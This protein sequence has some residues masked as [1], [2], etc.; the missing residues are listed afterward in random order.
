MQLFQ[1]TDTHYLTMRR[2]ALLPMAKAYI[3]SINLAVTADMSAVNTSISKAHS[4]IYS[5]EH[6]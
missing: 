6:I 5:K 1:L 3:Q 4:M 2:N